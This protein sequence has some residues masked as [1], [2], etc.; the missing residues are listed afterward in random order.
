MAKKLK[1]CFPMIREEKE[2]LAG[3]HSLVIMD[4]VVELEGGSLANVEV[5]KL[6]YRFPGQRSACY[7]CRSSALFRLIFSSRYITIKVSGTDGMRGWF[8]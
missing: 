3:A 2:L 6:G 1:D 4:I 7:C 5:Q 8:S